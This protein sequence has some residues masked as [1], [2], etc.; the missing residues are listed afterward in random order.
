MDAFGV[1]PN[2]ELIKLHFQYSCIRSTFILNIKIHIFINFLSKSNLMLIPNAQHLP[3]TNIIC[4][5]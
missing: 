3:K 2:N 1:Y 5:I 4:I